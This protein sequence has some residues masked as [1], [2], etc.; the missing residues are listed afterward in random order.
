[1]P[2][3]LKMRK[4]LHHGRGEAPLG[5]I[6]IIGGAGYIGSVMTRELLQAGYRVRVLDQLLFGAAGVRALAGHPRFELQAGDLR[7][8]GDLRKAASG[9]QA[10]IHLGA[11][12]GDLAC[13]SSELAAWQINYE[14]T[15]S[16]L[17]VCRDAG[18][19]RLLFASTC[20]VYGTTDSLVDEESPLKPLS[21]YAVTKAASESLLLA[22]VSRCFHPTVLRLGTAF[23]WSPRPRF[24]LVVN[25]LAAK[26]FW[27]HE[28]EIL[29][30]AQ[31]RP[32]VHVRDVARA[33]LLALQSPPSAV[34]GQIF[35][36]GSACMT[37]PLSALRGAILESAPGTR[38][39]Y[40]THPDQRDYRVCF[41][42]IQRVLGFE[43]HTS[44]AEGI[45][46][47]HRHLK[48]DL[49]ADYTA[50]VF[51]N[52]LCHMLPSYDAPL[53][54]ADARAKLGRDRRN[55]LHCASPAPAA[56]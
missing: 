10:V 15:T 2:A 13:R 41:R 16:I 8:S 20:S 19:S 34:S 47:I 46:E 50:N 7:D 18:A 23:G 26:A 54:P 27:G 22:S 25:L 44:L 49:V 6:L 17:R 9:V 53:L 51:H 45:R 5:P 35:N 43:C 42:R 32:F 36:V 1:M 29:N 21:L 14:A 30:P 56:G 4:P 39:R 12:V 28:V 31:W 11:I 3:Y 37:H 52:H 48:L 38:V 55:P 40:G 33:F 24:D